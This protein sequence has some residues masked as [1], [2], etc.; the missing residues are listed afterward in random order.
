MSTPASPR[1][2]T[3][4]TVLAAK[5]AQLSDEARDMPQLDPRF[6][7]MLH[8]AAR[9]A[10][11]LEPYVIACTTAESSALGALAAD[12]RSENWTGRFAAGET[13]VAL[14]QEMV[15]GHVEGQFLKLLVHAMR[16]TRILEIGLF[17]GYSAL[18]MAEALPDDGLLV[19]CELDPYAAAFAARAFARS[20]HQAKIR[21]ELG[22]AMAS[23]A[24][25]AAAGAT[26]DLI[27]IDADKPSYAAYYDY[28]LDN[29][30]L[31][32]AGLIC[33]DNTL[34]QGEPYLP[35]ERSTN[36]RAIADF[37]RMVAADPRVEQ[38]L[39]PLRDGVTMIR[40]VAPAPPSRQP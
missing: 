37:N 2:V 5:L 10:T 14:E 40:R 20:P 29:A 19:A 26:F 7:D 1:P 6:V 38:V 18:A 4:L 22:P 34:M 35:G 8:D 25:L 15:S 21:I 36:G 16:A 23:I 32:P 13:Q 12:T 24:R 31:S 3:P 27:F 33:V 17:T 28:V 9:L 39:L 11:G 30:L